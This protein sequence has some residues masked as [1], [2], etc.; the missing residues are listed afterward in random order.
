M[1]SLP[2]TLLLSLSLTAVIDFR[3]TSNPFSKDKITPSHQ[4]VKGTVRL[5]DGS[6]PGGVFVWLEQLDISTRTDSTGAFSL[7]I[8]APQTQPG[9]GINGVYRLYYYVANYQ[10]AA[11]ATAIVKGSFVYG[12]ENIDSN[13]NIKPAIVM[14]KLFD[15]D[16]KVTPTIFPHDSTG[17]ILIYISLYN[18]Q[19]A[20]EIIWFINRANQTLASIAL[21]E[22]G[23]A[24]EE[25]VLVQQSIWTETQLL[26][27]DTV[28]S[29]HLFS[30]EFSLPPGKYQVIPYLF[31]EQENLPPKLLQSLGRCYDIYHWHT[32]YLKIP[33]KQNIGYLTI[34]E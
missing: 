29:M 21:K 19:K 25:T 5:N 23:A 11:S 6:D 4:I 30:R 34:V 15:I 10:I 13:G 3:C 24:D 17:Y 22:V 26:S 14:K 12:E 9:G 7:E 8:P 2:L 31:I 32:D 1:K 20:T 18:I 27:S 28:L 33:F 16:T